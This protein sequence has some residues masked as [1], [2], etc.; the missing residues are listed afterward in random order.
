MVGRVSYKQN[1]LRGA[2]ALLVLIALPLS[3]FAADAAKAR[4]S[5]SAGAPL[6]SGHARSD[7]S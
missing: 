1:L 4:S 7:A 3:A 2:I 5:P 6:P